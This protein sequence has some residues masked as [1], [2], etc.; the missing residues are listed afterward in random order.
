MQDS[1]FSV[2][3]VRL[4]P[5]RDVCKS[6]THQFLY[7][8]CVKAVGDSAVDFAF[9]PSESERKRKTEIRTMRTEKKLSEFDLLFISNS[10]TS[11]LV[12]LP[13]LLKNCGIPYKTSER[14]A[15]NTK[16]LI[17]MGGSNAL[18]SQS[19]LFN[20]NDA[21]VDAL[22][23][24][25]GETLNEKIVRELAS[26]PSQNRREKLIELQGKI[27]GL[28]VFGAPEVKIQK[29]IYH[30]PKAEI[31]ASAPQ[32]LF[33]SS[34]ACSARL[35]IAYDCPAFCTFCFEGWERKPY[36]EI[37]GDTLL[38]AARNLK[39]KTGADTLEITAF[40]FNTHTDVTKLM[41]GLTRMFF[42][43]NFM[44]QRADILASNPGLVHY[45]VVSGKR[46]H[47]IGV[48]GIS[49]R[50]RTYFNK[51]LSEETALKAITLLLN[52]QVREI[53]LFYII[54]GLET[55]EDNQNYA[56]F[57]KKIAALKETYG[58]KTRIL[59]SFG[60]LVRMPF[61][62][63]RYEKLM[64]TEEEWKP[65]VEMI[66]QTTESFGYEFRLT[67][68]YNEFF[69]SQCL[70]LTNEKC[71]STLI[72]IAEHGFVYDQGIN[73]GA[74]KLFKEQHPLTQEFL[75]EKGEDYHFAF[76][77]VDTHI[78]SSFLYKRF[79]NAK[80]NIQTPMCLSTKCSGC[81]SCTESERK[82]LTEHQIHMPTFKDTNEMEQI[83]KAKAK[84]QPVYIEFN[85]PQEW[86]YFNSETIRARIMKTVMEKL[87]STFKENSSVQE[88]EILAAD[89][90]MTCRDHYFGSKLFDGKLPRWF[91]KNI[92][93]IYPFDNA[94]RNELYNSL[95]KTGFKVSLEPF[96]PK[97]FS[98]NLYPK[99][100][101]SSQELSKTVTKILNNNHLPFTMS[102]KDSFINFMIAPKA[103]KKRIISSAFCNDEKISLQGT[104]KMD[105]S[106]AKAFKLTAEFN[107]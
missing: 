10:F 96:T 67:Y 75:D 30:E 59:C 15:S 16:P 82:N 43:V 29:A 23:F 45:E 92:Y 69:L 37:D 13:Y 18:A 80:N 3:I 47:T 31:L 42:N 9:F 11:E 90:I 76:D 14:S 63:L 22:F 38:K 62:P 86:A 93:E 34:E 71:A 78:P 99:T 102:K 64:L 105:L 56:D 87:T 35:F 72:D 79:L 88:A 101:V 21:L 51:N 36:R 46:Q 83:V 104:E 60:L 4:S 24:G 12:N 28:K 6:I 53:K 95:L 49:E 61:T 100:A 65:I 40:N 25:E 41:T 103:V 8:E 7:G 2:A 39:L 98:V 70:C 85:V 94:E 68:D 50:M 33:D 55:K 77:F 17:V 44:S 20:E 27:P 26:V 97:E 73:S 74:W 106:S 1:D 58:E 66:R 107:F 57:L 19:I 89:K 54:S 52:E 81:S 48:E 5:F 91:G 84:A 32:Y